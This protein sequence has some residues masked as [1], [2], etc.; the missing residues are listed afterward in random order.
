MAREN[1]PVHVEAV[2]AGEPIFWPSTPCRHGH[3]SQRSTAAGRCIEC[4]RE[5]WWRW[6]DRNPEA[7][8]AHLERMLTDK[9]VMEG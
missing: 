7:A 1:D 3:L 2:L 9:C 8:L 4:R 6:R 5:T